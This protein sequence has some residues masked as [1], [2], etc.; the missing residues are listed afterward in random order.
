MTDAPTTTAVLTDVEKNAEPRVVLLTGATG[1]IGSRLV[2]RLLLGGHTVHGT[3]RGVESKRAK[4]VME[5]P[6]AADRLKLFEADLL[7]EGSFD[8]AMV[9]CD[10]VF[11][12]ASPYANGVKAADADRILFTPAVKGTENVLASVNK[13]E[14]VTRVVLTSSCVAVYGKIPIEGKT[15][16]RDDWN[17]TCSAEYLPYFHSK[18]LAEKAAWKIANSQSRWTMATMN[19]SIVLG[20]PAIENVSG[21]SLD[22]VKLVLSGALYPF[23]PPIAA[24]IVDVHDVCKAHV[25]AMIKR[26]V[27]GRFILNGVSTKNLLLCISDLL[28]P[29]FGA[30]YWLPT[31]SLSTYMR[32]LFMFLGPLM[33]LEKPLIDASFGRDA[34]FDVSATVEELGMTFASPQAGLEEAAE[35]LSK[36]SEVKN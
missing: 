7:A 16:T 4:A 12:V 32:G 27:T 20:A 34:K 1:F 23:S 19:P 15:Y 36:S 14:S 33:G 8:A 6:G 21:E 30:K 22:M 3:C 10:T 11:H 2:E 29:K 24:G 26:D 35:Y 31:R 25:L 9:G 5:L 18:Y 17:E 28:R 13:C